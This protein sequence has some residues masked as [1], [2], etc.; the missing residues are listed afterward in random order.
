[1]TKTEE[2]NSVVT[3]ENAA[4][5]VNSITKCMIQNQMTIEHLE[6]AYELTREF[7][8]KNATIKKAD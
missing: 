2:L 7:Y 6:M 3:A 4:I 5:L 8:K 1:M